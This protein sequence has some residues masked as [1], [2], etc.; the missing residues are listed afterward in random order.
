MKSIIKVENLSKSFATNHVLDDISFDLY[1]GD[2][3]GV[4]GK[5]GTGKSVLLQCI[6][7]YLTP[8]N[9]NIFIKDV[10]YTNKSLKQRYK[11][12]KDIS[13]LFQG[14]ALFD[15]MSVYD[16][17]VFGLNL[18]EKSKQE[19]DDLVK[20]SLESVKLSYDTAKK[21][22]SELS[23][24]M[25]KRVA[26]A[27][28]I[29]KKPSIIFF[30]EPTSGLDPITTLAIDKLIEKITKDLKATSIIITHDMKSVQRSTNRLILLEDKKIAWEG[31]TKD[32]EK[33]GNKSLLSFIDPC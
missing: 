25:K 31:L 12:N 32:I 8:E 3:L 11:L 33:S 17:I 9:G 26:F 14:S 20:E 23:G 30:D 2:V 6:L 1:E 15:S 19:I 22:S 28:A 27:R 10:N 24:G 4:I 18:K 7:G 5:S 13:M 16:N 29:A 21:F